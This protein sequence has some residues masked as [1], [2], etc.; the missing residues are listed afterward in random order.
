MKALIID[1]PRSMKVADINTP[2]IGVSDVLVQIKATGV[3]AGD[4][5]IYHGKS[6]YAV[7]P[8]VG[9]HEIAGIIATVGKEVK[10]IRT[11]DRVV[12]DPFIGCGK[13]YAC[14]V[15]KY[16]C[17]SRLHILGV[18]SNGGFA[19]YMAV[20]VKQIFKVP[21][22]LPLEIAAFA[23]PIAIGIQ[24]C[25]R[26]ELVAGETVLV[27]GCGPIGM[28]TIE[29]A[30]ARG[31]RVI[32]ADINMERLSIAGKMGAETI[33]SDN[34]LLS[35][36]LSLTNGEGMPVVIEATGVPQMMELTVDLVA[37]GG[38]IVIVGLVPKGVGITFPGLDF[39]R[40]ELTIHGSR[41]NKSC[42]PEAIDLLASG[43]LVFPS[44]AK[45]FSMWDGAD[46]FTQLGANP[47]LHHKAIL[48]TNK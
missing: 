20:P 5:H 34:N 41:T 29:V 17:C 15:G 28:V 6:P 3:C 30:K 16:N 35:A 21:D 45:Q 31:A 48:L 24:A 11:G 43:K 7:Y 39:T 4:I 10:T 44:L 2:N 1:K 22:H 33:F 36:I 12:V 40:K 9:G 14:S 19:E 47:A 8:I 27:L 23:E 37:A 32:A 25:N 26:G 42:F 13:C 38:R 46:L 18:H